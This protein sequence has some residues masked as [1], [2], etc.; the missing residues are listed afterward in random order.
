MKKATLFAALVLSTAAFSQNLKISEIHIS[1]GTGSMRGQDG[2]L[3]DFAKLAPN[4]AILGMDL[5]Q[6][7]PYNDIYNGFGLNFHHLILTN[8][9]VFGTYF[10]IA[11]IL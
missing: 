8:N 7:K 1:S 2:T 6:L 4:S 5:S 9:A 11:L 10:F 3:S